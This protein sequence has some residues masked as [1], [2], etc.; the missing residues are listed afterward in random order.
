MSKWE[1]ADE[2]WEPRPIKKLRQVERYARNLNKMVEDDS[3]NDDE[4]QKIKFGAIAAA[5]MVALLFGA[6]SA[7]RIDPGTV[8]VQIKLGEVK[9]EALNPG[10]HFVFPIVSRIAIMNVQVAKLE[11]KASAVSKDLQDTKSIVALNYH[12]DGSRAPTVFS[13]IGM[14]YE[15][16]IIGPALQESFKAATAKFTASEMITERE[17]VRNETKSMLGARLDKYGIIMDDFSIVNFDFSTSF[18]KAIEDKQTAEQLAMKAARDLDRIKIEAEQKIA[19]ARAEA[20]SLRI[21]KS[22]I[23]DNLIRLRAIEVMGEAVKKWNGQLPK[24]VSGSAPVLG[25]SP[26]FLDESVTPEKPRK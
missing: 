24:V 9:Q 14:E 15:A 12:I 3:M 21:Q 16:K 22:E 1:K 10:L 11:A 2:D 7:T 8:G 18:A 5:L 19:T 20:E 6:C 25:M 23:T 17:R 4:M 26:S 13:D